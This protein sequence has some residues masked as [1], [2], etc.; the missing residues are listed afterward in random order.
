MTVEKRKE[1]LNACDKNAEWSLESTYQL[2]FRRGPVAQRLEKITRLR[3][4]VDALR[5]R[6]VTNFI[7][8]IDA[9]P[10]FLRTAAG[11]IEI[12]DVNDAAV[13]FFGAACREDLIGPLDATLSLDDP[14]TA[15]A[16]R[17][18][19]RVVAGEP[20]GSDGT[21]TAMGADML[22]HEIRPMVQ[23]EG[24]GDQFVR[25]TELEQKLEAERTLL[26]TVI[27]NV[28]DIIFQKDTEGRFVL[29]NLS[30]ANTIGLSDPRDMIGKTDLDV[31]PREIAQ[32]FMS[33]D[34]VV[35]ETARQHDNIEEPLASA[36]GSLKWVLTTKV[37]LIDR[38]GRVTGLIGIGRDITARKELQTKNQQLATLVEYADDAIVGLDLDGRITAWN[39]GAERLYGYAAEEAIGAPTALFVPPDAEE[40]AL[41]M[42]E[43]LLRGGQVT[44]FE[45][46]RLRKDGA[47]ITVSLTLS[48]IRD[49]EGRITGVASVARDITKHKQA[50][51]ALRE[52]EE[53]FRSVVTNAPF[54]IFRTTLDGRLISGNPMFATIMGYASPE[55]IVAA[56][57][58]TS[59]GQVLYEDPAQRPGI[60]ERT[61]RSGRWERFEC[62]FRRK[63][64]A[65]ITTNLVF[66][67]YENPDDGAIEL[68]GFV[69]DISDRKK[70][71][72]A[73]R[74][75]EERYRNLVQNLGEGLAII[76]QS[77]RIQFA[78][79]AAEK[80]FGVPAGGLVGVN[81]MAHLEKE[82]AASFL[83]EI[84]RVPRGGKIAYT[85]EISRSDGQART[86][87]FAVSPQFDQ[88]EKFTA[89]LVAFHDITEQKRLEESLEQERRLLLT[90][91]N[92]LPDY[93]YLKDTEGRFILVNQAQARL[94]RATDPRDLI[95]RKDSDYVAENLACKYRVDDLRVIEGARSLVNIEEQTQ[96]VAG[97]L[98]WVLTTKVPLVGIDG[99]VTGLVGISRDITERKKT[100]EE[101]R[102]SEKK[103][104]LLL[105]TLNEG[106]WA[107]D[108]DDITSFVNPRMASMMG[109]A[110]EELLGRS[111]Y[112]FLDPPN[113]DPRLDNER[114]RGISGQFD[115]EI[116]RKDGT[117]IFTRS[118]SAP[119]VG[120]NGEYLGS[121][122]SVI[123]LTEQRKAEDEVQR[124]QGQLL[125]AQKMEAIGRLAGGVAHDFNNLLMTILGNIEL[126]KEREQARGVI[127]ECAEQV[128]RA[129]LRAAEL[130]HQLLAF[131]RK[132]MLQPKVLDLNALVENLS[133]MLRRLIGE[134]V[135]LE[136]HPG[137][138]IGNVKAD[139]GQIEQVILNLAVN[140]R[141]AMPDGGRLILETRNSAADELVQ[142]GRF[143]ISPGPYVVLSIR[144]TGVGMDETV[145]AHLFE[146]FFT[147]KEAGRGTGLGLS[148]VYGIVK[149][150]GGY[151]LVDSQ[152][153]KGTTFLILL[154]R[155]EAT[156]ALTALPAERRPTGGTERI[157]IV[158][159]DPSVLRLVTHML[160]DFGYA[161][162]SA[163]TPGEALSIPAIETE[164]GVDLLVSDVVLSEM[165][166]TELAR[167][168][169]QRSPD[170]KVLFISGYTD[171]TTFRK[172]VLAEGDAFLLKPFTRNVLGTKVRAVL[173]GT[174]RE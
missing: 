32:K 112:G 101:L 137:T 29:A 14:G 4:E 47:R 91:I 146:P 110:E 138:G 173:D 9:Q 35:L 53:H 97:E 13:Q 107:I 163:S 143:D 49:A 104:R 92:N 55:E 123:D 45:T 157:L 33:D 43:Q 30:L 165:K 42:R 69:E 131:S 7:A 6:G 135:T 39:R 25:H 144:D 141:D 132:Q 75:S 18:D 66:R 122:A 40:E 11:M 46:T 76:D 119:I 149:Q 31:F 2:A 98:K 63:D 164:Q 73:I 145:R 126:I 95:G 134:D 81:V 78:N 167:R 80:I 108:K 116:V 62:R 84:E 169:R 139:P 70:A 129:G 151:V 136:L 161:V 64:G 17:E 128:Q 166:G 154:P 170:L 3:R 22:V 142:Y 150:S 51:E 54:G 109:Y 87:E 89:T 158:E 65:F 86:L 23:A 130:T 159:D 153:G 27:D 48:A 41:R 71:E 96:G 93:I 36:S 1:E 103:Y 127:V 121:I 115:R 172:G 85:L 99:K 10:G 171:E 68:E 82:R 140:A 50:E 88:K 20:K 57:N 56:V 74:E 155:V 105:D 38:T 90:L 34:R 79:P 28:P 52:S 106:I 156:D 118:K 100:E 77:A 174:R 5:S 147:T 8:Y 67:G 24:K 133:K 44:R 26:R 58:R 15:S 72:E 59:I 37:P 117:R 152:P 168:M 111:I 125:Q 94:V 83:S 124:L 148:T 114:R 60:V 160:Q 61:V 120:E 12:V 19:V 16:V 21:V 102:E 113:E 162:I